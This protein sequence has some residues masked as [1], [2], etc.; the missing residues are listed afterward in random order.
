M[1]IEGI[2]GNTAEVN[3]SQQLQTRAATVSALHEASLS[4][5]AFA[6]NAVS[7]DIDTGD[8]MLLVRNDSS[9]KKLVI[10]KA[11]VWAD[12]AASFDIHVVTASFTIAGTAVTGVCLNKASATVADATAKADETGNTQGDIIATTRNT[13][14]VR[15]NGDDNA[16]IAAASEGRW[17][18]LS[19]SVILGENQ[20]IAVDIQGESAAF[21][22]TIIGYF[23]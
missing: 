10:E 8:T 13:R 18:D 22:C 6:W 21:E 3:S 16:D 11:Y 5:Q 14:Y 4:G 15:G 19:G 17:V 20:A 12:V 7:A 2:N 23:L 9:S 1:K